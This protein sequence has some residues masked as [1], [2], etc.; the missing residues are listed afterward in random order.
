MGRQRLRLLLEAAVFNAVIVT[1]MAAAVIALLGGAGS[2]YHTVTFGFGAARKMDRTH[3]WNPIQFAKAVLWLCP[4]AAVTCGSF[5]FIAAL[6]GGGLLHLRARR[7]R[8]TK[9]FLVEAGIIGFLLA[10][11]FPVFDVWAGQAQE[12]R[13]LSYSGVDLL[14]PAFGCLCAWICAFVYRKRVTLYELK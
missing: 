12:I 5:G 10:F 13:D 6:A 14:A 8:S 9:R 7:L 1:V 3:I 4:I 11:L 2:E